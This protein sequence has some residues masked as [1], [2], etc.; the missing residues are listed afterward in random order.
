MVGKH[1]QCLC[2]GLAVWNEYLELV[3]ICGSSSSQARSYSIPTWEVQ[4]ARMAET[5]SSSF[6]K[7]EEVRTYKREFCIF[8]GVVK[9][10]MDFLRGVQ[11]LNF[12]RVPSEAFGEEDEE[13]STR[14]RTVHRFSG[15][16][17][18][19][20]CEVCISYGTMME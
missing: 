20:G 8:P 12:I 13:N 14:R 2:E 19:L 10:Y 5:S 3:T 18:S 17:V 7:R 4:R 15:P 9:L 1:S 6:P 16:S 11:I